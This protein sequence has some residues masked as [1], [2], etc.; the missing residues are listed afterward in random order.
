MQF[1]RFAVLLL[2]LNITLGA[3]I[4]TTKTDLSPVTLASVK[5]RL[6][7]LGES[8]SMGAIWINSEDQWDD[9]IDIVSGTT[10][11]LPQS[12]TMPDI[13]FARYGILLIR[14]GEKPTGGYGLELMENVAKIE[15]RM[16]VVHVR[17][18]EP[19]K[20][21]ITTQ[22]ITYPYLMIRMARG[23]FDGIT[24]IDQDGTVRATVEI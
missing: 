7:N 8:K 9:L 1:N 3:C 12:G 10:N 24:V 11:N 19:E 20:G 13:D 23:A 5:S 15:S 22:V 18:I 4:H 21:S 14:M 16:A 6:Q 17:W 2:G